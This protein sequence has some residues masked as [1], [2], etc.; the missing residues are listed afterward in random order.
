MIEELLQ[1]SSGCRA[2][3]VKEASRR[4]YGYRQVCLRCSKK[5]PRDAVVVFAVG[6]REWGDLAARSHRAGRRAAC[7][8]CTH[9][10]DD[11]APSGKVLAVSAQC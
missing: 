8:P 5:R 11:G 4:S 9:W 1:P 6:Q 2:R 10:L 3:G 7:R